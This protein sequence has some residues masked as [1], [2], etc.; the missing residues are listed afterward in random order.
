MSYSV[1]RL[2]YGIGKINI[3]W[4][5]MQSTIF[6]AFWRLMGSDVGRAAPLFF[7]IKTD[8]AQRDM[9]AALA[10]SKLRSEPVLLERFTAAI[11][12]IGK[13]AGRRNDFVHTMWT[14]DIANQL[15]EPWPPDSSRLEGKNL[16]TEIEELYRD[17]GD[18]HG[19][20]I[21]CV[22]EIQKTVPEVPLTPFGTLSGPL[23]E[24]LAQHPEQAASDAEDDPPD[25]PTTRP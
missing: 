12:R 11:G 3:A 23:A 20:L 17:I 15:A 9:T 2:T 21:E 25:N 4:T 19:E 18:I 10:K 6:L 5:G 1:E 7:A 24:W 8:R 14:I 13:L 16:E 22:A